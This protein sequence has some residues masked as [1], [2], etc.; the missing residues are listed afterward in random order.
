[1]KLGGE[2]RSC[3]RRGGGTSEKDEVSEPEIVSS[4]LKCLEGLIGSPESVRGS[5]EA[6]LNVKLGMLARFP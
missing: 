1:M 4:L 2:M 3:E 6:E 5:V